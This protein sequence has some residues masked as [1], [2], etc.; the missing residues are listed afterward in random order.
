[1]FMFDEGLER[2]VTCTHYLEL[3]LCRTKPKCE[4]TFPK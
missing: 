2:Y 1:M 4:G 3:V